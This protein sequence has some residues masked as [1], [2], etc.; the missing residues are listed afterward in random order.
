M[1]DPTIL[2][3]GD[4]DR[5]L[6]VDPAHGG[7]ATEAL[8]TTIGPYRLLRRIG[9]GG[10]GEVFEAEQ[11][12]PIR[13][14]VALKVIKPGMDSRAVIARFDAERQALALMDHPCIAK[15]FA[16]G[17]TQRGRPYFVME[18]VEGE[19][20]TEYCDR[21]RLS[22]RERL[23][24][25]ILVCEGVQHAHQKAVIHRDLKPSNVLVGEVDGRPAPKIIDFGVAKATT[26]RLTELT[27]VTEQGQ[28]LGTPEYMSPE[29]ASSAEDDIDTRT[30][31]YA[32]GV[33][34]YEL[35]AGALPFEPRDLRKAGHDAIR[36]I[37]REQDPPRPSTR[38]S[39]LGDRATTIAEAH[40]SAPKRL[41]SE[42]R[43]DLDWIT[44]KA[45]E[46]DR[47]RRYAT[48]SDFAADV[49]RYLD[50]EPVM[51]GPPSASYRLRKLVRR[52]RGAFAA[53]ASLV[54][55]LAVLAVSMTVQAGRLARERDRTAVQAAKAQRTTEFLQSMLAG[56]TPATAR[57]R[58][59]TL[60]EEILANTAKRIGPE[61]AEQP[62]VEAAIR[63]TLGTTYMSLGK[64]DV[65]EAN[66]LRADSLQTALIG[67]DA[68]ATLATRRQLGVLYARTGR[69]AEA[70][71]RLRGV[72]AGASRS[73][74]LHDP[75][76]LSAMADLGD[77]LMRAGKNK[78]SL[79]V[80]ESS[81]TVV[82]AGFAPT[83]AALLQAKATLAI[84][85]YGERR[86]DEAISL[87]D[88]V[89]AARIATLG[90]DHPSTIAA[91]GNLALILEQ[92]GRPGDAV[93]R[94]REV[95]AAAT[96]IYGPEHPEVL[97]VENN[98]A[99]CLD[100]HD[101]TAEAEAIQ[102]RLVALSIRLFGPENSE[103]MLAQANLGRY[104][105]NQKRYAAAQSLLDSTLAI[106]RRT[107]GPDHLRTTTTLTV[108]AD[109][110]NAQRR[111]RD[112]A[113]VLGQLAES[114]GHTEG[115]T[116]PTTVICFY[117]WAAKLQDMGDDRAAEPVFRQ[118]L[119]RHQ[120]GGGADAPYVAAILNGLGKAVDARGAHAESDSL[121]AAGLAMR[122][123]LFGDLN[124]EVAYS[125]HT[126]G[127][128][129]SERGDAA[130]AVPYLR[131]CVAIRDSLLADDEWLR[132][133]T[134]ADLGNCL[135][136][137]GQVD[138]GIVYLE[139]AAPKLES[140]PYTA[141]LAASARG[142]LKDG[143]RKRGR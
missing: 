122:R 133:G 17:A 134:R 95:V 91:K 49:R 100:R 24:L 28:L 12:E 39:G 118:A 116:S 109:L 15:V 112:A 11:S 98:L 65:A 124:L 55:L 93:A 70:E 25:F 71:A 72:V 132:W 54:L 90:E 97:K 89:L 7:G 14:R 104:L 8:G 56:V 53:G 46:K 5:T 81:V 73:L 9:E 99:L 113:G 126:L 27:M 117:N 60:L 86:F 51:A 37:I 120:R 22:L 83:D 131:E 85:L 105:L 57:G 34:L 88:E 102:R 29:Q 36:K 137:T 127:A 75:V 101:Q 1:D 6:P 78:E 31:V 10:M 52:N 58:D 62:E 87:Y 20:I 103:T 125:L 79:A 66:L 121:M 136:K 33:V 13:R 47:D 111:Y 23:E 26:Q 59:T 94:N 50:D 19:P 129:H 43:G 61:L 16:A 35:L 21:R 2:Q 108:I 69:H 3:P 63:A 74:G 140:F 64:F 84:I 135:I 107:L 139:S 80:A 42:L 142:W 76:L 30:D 96:R 32:L 143:Y 67:P 68:A 141:D 44:M 110:Y 82:G 106:C 41:Q 4:H 18:Y 128:V 92:A 123:R 130:G 45:L 48:S 119:D 38:F 40:G 77:V 114:A 138:E 115:E